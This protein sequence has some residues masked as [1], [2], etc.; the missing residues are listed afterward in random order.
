MSLY[1]PAHPLRG[2]V[3]VTPT[4]RRSDPTER[5]LALPPHYAPA[6]AGYAR[7]PFLTPALITPSGW[8]WRNAR[9]YTVQSADDMLIYRALRITVDGEFVG[10]WAVELLGTPLPETGTLA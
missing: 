5:L 8:R 10:W 4:K 9:T 2:Y 6:V 7:G 1:D 3:E